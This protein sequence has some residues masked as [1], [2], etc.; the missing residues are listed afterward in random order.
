MINVCSFHYIWEYKFKQLGEYH[1]FN[2]DKIYLKNVIRLILQY[3][4]LTS[5]IVNSDM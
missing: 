3:F 2:A 4:L 5:I 1:N